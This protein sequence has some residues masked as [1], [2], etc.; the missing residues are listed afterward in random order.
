MPRWE[1]QFS[2]Q[3][4]RKGKFMAILTLG[5]DL[6]KNVFAVHGVNEAGVAQLRQPKVTRAKL[7]ALIAALPPCTISIK[8]RKRGARSCLFM[9]AMAKELQL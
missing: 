3:L 1:V 9:P 8:A 5:I 4:T 2:H 7:N 6:A